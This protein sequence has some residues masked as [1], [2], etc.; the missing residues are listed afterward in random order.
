MKKNI[1]FFIL[2][3]LINVIFCKFIFSGEIKYREL[4]YFPF[5]GLSTPDIINETEITTNDVIKYS[6]ILTQLATLSKTKQKELN[7]EDVERACN[8]NNLSY[9]R[10]FL[11]FCK[12]PMCKRNN[13]NP[14]TDKY[15]PAL[16]RWIK[17]SEFLSC[18]DQELINVRESPEIDSIFYNLKI[19]RQNIDEKNMSLQRTK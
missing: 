4:P 17:A 12:I 10:F 18:T 14:P 1:I 19:I 11:L 8:T 15:D 13:Y 7:F 9:K 3:L 16:G 6:N 5:K 2:V